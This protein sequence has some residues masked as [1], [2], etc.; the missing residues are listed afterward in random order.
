MTLAP[1]AAYRVQV[2]VLHVGDRAVR[3]RLPDREKEVWLP[4]CAILAPAVAELGARVSTRV[5]VASWYARKALPWLVAAGEAVEV[6]QPAPP[7]PAGSIA[8]CR[9]LWDAA[10]AAAVS[11]R[12]TILNRLRHLL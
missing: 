3:V 6:K 10:L 11:E 8:E 4:R 2:E 9:A 7:A 5:S 1:A 12:A